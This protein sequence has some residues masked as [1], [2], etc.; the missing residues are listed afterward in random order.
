MCTAT[1]REQSGKTLKSKMSHLRTE[2]NTVLAM[3]K[4][5]CRKRHGNNSL[6]KDCED[7]FQ[8]AEKRLSKCSFG[9]DKPQCKHCYIHCYSKEMK[10]KI[11]EVMRFSGP[12]MMLRHPVLAIQH[13]L[14]QKHP[15]KKTPAKTQRNKG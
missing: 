6:C 3:I 1:V 10:E 11:T 15:Q 9:E 7:L 5:Y 13:L 2:R 12:K 8:Y 14:N 4:I